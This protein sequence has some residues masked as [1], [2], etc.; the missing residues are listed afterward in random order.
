VH[1]WL[2]GGSIVVGFSR[3]IHLT[4]LITSL[5]PVDYEEPIAVDVAKPIRW[6]Q[7]GTSKR[8]V[9]SHA[10]RI[11]RSDFAAWLSITVPSFL[12]QTSE[13]VRSDLTGRFPTDRVREIDPAKR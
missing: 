1:A 5:F 13:N 2:S 7:D 11:M 3:G 8:D 10:P 4:S 9:S 6:T 12:Q